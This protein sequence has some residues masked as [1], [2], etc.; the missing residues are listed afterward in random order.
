MKIVHCCFGVE[1]Y[2][3]TWGYQQ[4]LL[5]SYC[6][7]LGNET[8][9]LASNDTFPPFLND[10]AIQRIRDK[11]NSYYNDLV[12][13]ERS[14]SF[15]SGCI[16][17]QIAKHLKESL[18][19]EA[20][21]VIF[22]H[23]CLNLSLFACVVYKKQ[24]PEVRLFVD[25]HGDVYN[26]R[27][28]KLYRFF[29]FKI[30]LSLFHHFCQRYVDK[31]YGVTYG[32]CS[33]LK[34]YLHIPPAKISLLPIGADVDAMNGIKENRED[35]RQRF[36]FIKGNLIIIHG[37]KLDERKGTIVL[38]DAYRE[39]KKLFPHLCLILFGEITDPRIK[40]KLDKDIIVYD[41]L[42]RTQTFELLKIADLAIWPVHHTTLIED[43]VAA[44]V[45]YLIRKTETTKHLI[46]SDFYLRSGDKLELKKMIM[47]FLQDYSA[48]NDYCDRVAEIR[49]QISYY[50]IAKEITSPNKC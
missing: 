22:F 7:K 14:D 43:C 45:P 5:P 25:N 31:Y 48:N 32:R 9:V 23:G 13:V 33:F 30:F 16:H 44:G 3:D 47:A 2:I 8:V 10:E 11:G 41:W 24:H 18:R 37:G 26:V 42:S 17:L 35:L 4:N 12:R 29:Y 27:D 36:G 50:T 20:P 49:K 28:N 15:F 46:N 21:N 19:K 38:I 40:L 6:A 39:L 1:H 34:D